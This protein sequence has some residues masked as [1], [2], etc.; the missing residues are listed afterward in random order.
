MNRYRVK[1]GTKIDLSQRDPNDTSGFAGK[2]Q[3]AKQELLA[4]NRRLDELQELLYAQGEHKL[5]RGYLPVTTHSAHYI[6]HPGLRD[7]VADYL[8]HERDDVD[9]MGDILR[10]HG[11]FR[12]NLDPS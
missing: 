5:S 3:E 8:K 1:P 10:Q 6:T 11:P 4:L 12:K 9:R 7:A 2:K